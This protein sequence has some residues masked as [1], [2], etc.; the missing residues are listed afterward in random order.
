MAVIRIHMSRVCSVVVETTIPDDL[1]SDSTADAI[2]A[3]IEEAMESAGKAELCIHC[4]GLTPGAT[5][6][7]DLAGAVE[8]DGVEDT[9]TGELIREADATWTRSFGPSQL[10][11]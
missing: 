7:R 2:D 4:T 11:G 9:G 6:H 3:R 8:F 1:D 10:R 5:V